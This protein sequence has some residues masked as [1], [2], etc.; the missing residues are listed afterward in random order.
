[1][2]YS[3]HVNQ[4]KALE[5]KMTLTEAIVFD[6]IVRSAAWKEKFIL[7]N[8]LY[9]WVAKSKVLTDLPIVTDKQ[10]TIYNIYKSLEKKGLIEYEIHNK[11]DLISIKVSSKEWDFQKN[12][13]SNPTNNDENSDSNPTNLG[14][15]SDKLPKN[16]DSNPTYKEV[17]LLKGEGLESS[18]QPSNSF[19]ILPTNSNSEIIGKTKEV[20]DKPSPS[21]APLPPDVKNLG[22]K[23][24]S[25]LRAKMRAEMD[26]ILSRTELDLPT[27]SEMFAEYWIYNKGREFDA[28]NWKGLVSSFQKWFEVGGNKEL[29]KKEL[30]AG[31]N[32]RGV[33]EDIIE[34]VQKKK[35][36][37]ISNDEI[38]ELKKFLANTILT[39]EQLK[40]D[41]TKRFVNG[42][43][44]TW[45]YWLRIAQE[46]QSEETYHRRLNSK[47]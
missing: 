10:D 11:K 18:L 5:W 32:A 33:M 46:V 40:I 21:N 47:L 4:I 28:K 27:L 29:P 2:R 42:N 37:E 7:N 43:A 19:S 23:I 1:M 16:S 30:S 15:K 17:S 20:S 41:V 13:D 6:Y 45:K 22:V 8:K 12:S 36:I 3:L 39:D 35:K 38:V 25:V 14:F 34:Y 44:S 9:Y 24:C 31:I 26:D